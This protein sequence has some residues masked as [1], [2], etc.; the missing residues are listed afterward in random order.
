MEESC[1]KGESFMAIEY[2][3]HLS[4]GDYLLLRKSVGFREMP[5]HQAETGLHNT[6]YLVAAVD[7]GRT[8]GMARILWDGGYAVLLTDVVVHPDYQGKRIGA[9]LIG[10]ILDYLRSQMEPGDKIMISLEAA[11]GKEQ[12]YRKLGFEERPNEHQGA[13]MTQLLTK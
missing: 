5:R 1:H 7:G 8:V 3:G 4:A 9:K 11:Q 13:G 6:P 2:V 12:F 10:K